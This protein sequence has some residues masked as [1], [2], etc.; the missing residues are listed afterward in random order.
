VSVKR[1]DAI[2]SYKPGS[3]LWSEVGPRRKTFVLVA[4]GG[5][6]VKLAQYPFLSLKEARREASAL[7]STGAELTGNR[8][9]SEG[10]GG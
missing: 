2:A 4:N 1:P 5:Y 9:A 7:R 10:S 6:R 8:A 3:W